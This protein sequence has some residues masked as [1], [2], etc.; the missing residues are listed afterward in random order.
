[1]QVRRVPILGCY[2]SRSNG[3]HEANTAVLFFYSRFSDSFRTFLIFDKI[4]IQIVVSEELAFSSRDADES[5]SM[6]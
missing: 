4:S 6:S 5:Q 1:M 2:F 3:I